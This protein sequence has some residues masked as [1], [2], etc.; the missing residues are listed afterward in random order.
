M[1]IHAPSEKPA[2]LPRVSARWRGLWIV[3]LGLVFV[4]YTL[5]VFALGLL[6]RP[7][8]TAY[9][10][11]AGAISLLPTPMKAAGLARAFWEAPGKYIQAAFF[12]PKTE[13]LQIDLKF[14]HLKQLQQKRDQALDLLLLIQGDD[15]YV[16]AT[17]R[18]GQKAYDVK[19]RLK[20]DEVD[21]LEGHKWSFRVHIK[22][23]DALFGM[24]RFSL[25][26]PW[27]RGYQ[28]EVLFQEA[29][30]KEGILTP[31]FQVVRVALNGKDLGLM[32]MEEHPS[33][34]MLT[35]Q[36][37]KESV[38]LRFDEDLYWEAT[39]HQ[40]P[41]GG[42]YNTPATTTIKTFEATSVMASPTLSRDYAQASGLLR[43]FMHQALPASAVFDVELLGK[44]LA[45]AE[46]WD[47]WHLLAWNNLR[48]Y[49]N[50]IT[51]KIEPIGFD[52][53]SHNPGL[54]ASLLVPSKPIQAQ[55]LEDPTVRTA[56]LNAVQAISQSITQGS[57]L[58]ELKKTETS[59]LQQLHQEFPLLQP[60]DFTWV[61]QRATQLLALSES[62]YASF[63][64]YPI[65]SKTQ[66]LPRL[67]Q[68]YQLSEGAGSR[69]ELVNI[70]DEPVIITA[71][72]FPSLASVPEH[73][74]VN[75][76]LELP[77]TR[78][79]DPPTV[80]SLPLPAE[81]H[82][83]PIQITAT[84][85]RQP[86]QSQTL[87]AMA[88]VPIK[89]KP[90]LAKFSVPEVLKIHPY[91]SWDGKQLAFQ[92]GQWTI[93]Q[94]LILPNN[95][96]L[97][98]PPGTQ[99]QFAPNTGLIAYGPLTFAGTKTQP[100]ILSAQ[101]PKQ[102]WQG[103]AVLGSKHASSWSYT[104]VK[105]T[106]GHARSGWKLP[107]AIVFYQAPI[108][109]SHCQFTDNHSKVALN[110]N[111]TVFSLNQVAF[112]N[113]H[114]DAL[115]T[116]FSSGSIHGGSF[117]HIGGNAVDASETLLTVKNTSFEY[118]QDKALSIG[119]KSQAEIV[120]INVKHASTGLAS[121]DQSKAS[122]TNALFDSIDHVALTAYMKQTGYGPALIEA[123][124]VSLLQ[125]PRPTLVQTGS[126]LLL[127]GQ[128][129]PTQALDIPT[130]HSSGGAQQ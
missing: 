56:Y 4:A 50:P 20:G 18:H 64:R 82:K 111:R 58:N 129:I 76:P 51:G 1:K 118:I 24:R 122:V 130:G 12:S 49:Y 69:L 96:G 120:N 42:L 57:Y 102:G 67:I 38:I 29:L 31:R 16:P 84:L 128:A 83:T 100:I 80:V 27:V 94:D 48:F 35:S 33:K 37:R 36:H 93:E 65:S 47:A 106:V 112:S 88:Y 117:R 127:N 66:A 26:A 7:R 23:G 62:N 8:I 101:N 17:I 121:N 74:V 5:F 77:P 45:T 63:S 90:V 86:T 87:E 6:E 39:A 54:S 104:T 46:V 13:T 3:L 61:Q 15:D 44:F 108:T 73:P 116:D 60:F 89:T 43:G 125:T 19:L 70:L 32:M 11:Q 78:F 52:A 95:V 103:V 107:G 105:H 72:H 97:Y 75:L 110:L 119:E 14:Q 115:D 34:E 41:G 92:A 91:L 40:I 59:W 28:S 22:E 114:A 21:H 10:K 113:I 85:K 109:L 9:L 25:Q 79:G 126:T 30:R 55:M 98:I 2:R 71:L 123:V 81:A 53:D 124:N 99:L 68:A